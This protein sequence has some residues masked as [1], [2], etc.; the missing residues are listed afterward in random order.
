[1]FFYTSDEHFGHKNAI[2]H[3]NRPFSNV[4]EMDKVIIER[5]NALVDHKD[6]V[7]HCGDFT[8]IRNYQR[9]FDKYV[10]KL[11]GNHIFLMGS[12]DEWLEKLRPPYIDERT[13]HTP[14]GRIMVV[15]CHYSM[16][17]WRKSHYGSWQVYG[18]SHGNLPPEGKQW[19]I[20]VDN[21]DFYP[22]PFSKLIDIMSRQPD[23]FNQIP[24]RSEKNEKI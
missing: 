3:S 19:D 23:N 6:T 4:D 21:N 10:S 7:I 12:H 2:K 5:H 17:V 9:V 8:L 13:H 24:E 15:S 11:N 16:K 1:M 18:H 22:V 14:A 20:G